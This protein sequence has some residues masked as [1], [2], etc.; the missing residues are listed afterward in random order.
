[1]NIQQSSHAGAA[2]VTDSELLD[3]AHIKPLSDAAFIRTWPMKRASANRYAIRWRGVRKTLLCT[4][5]LLNPKPA[6]RRAIP[7]DGDLLCN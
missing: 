6:V 2:P 5:H 7:L 3:M 4:F 1:M